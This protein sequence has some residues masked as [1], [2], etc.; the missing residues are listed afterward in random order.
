MPS[1]AI[2]LEGF[3]IEENSVILESDIVSVD[4]MT[5]HNLIAN[6]PWTYHD[7]AKVF[8]SLNPTGTNEL[9]LIWVTMKTLKVPSKETKK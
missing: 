4:S 2:F 8:M 3:N 1:K 9:M 7:L 5:L 6:V